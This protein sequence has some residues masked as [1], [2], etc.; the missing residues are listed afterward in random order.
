MQFSVVR[1]SDG[2]LARTLRL[3]NLMIVV[4]SVGTAN[5][6]DTPNLVSLVLLVILG[7]MASAVTK[8]VRRRRAAKSHG[9]ILQFTFSSQGA[10]VHTGVGWPE[11]I[12]WK[13][14]RRLRF[15]R[16]EPDT[17]RLTLGAGK[18]RTFWRG[19]YI[20]GVI[21]CNQRSAAVLRGEIHRRLHASRSD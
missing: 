19:R 16:I 15:D 1:P 14:L 17:W 11:I 12:P 2:W 13:E 21:N 8:W 4:W 20:V 5:W 10:G 7:C 6:V 18:W 3:L 9:G